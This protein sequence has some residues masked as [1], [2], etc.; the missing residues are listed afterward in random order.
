MRSKPISFFSDGFRGKCGGTRHSLRPLVS[1]IPPVNAFD[2][3]NAKGSAFHTGSEC[4]PTWVSFLLLTALVLP[5]PEIKAV[6]IVVGTS[7][8]T[9]DYLFSTPDHRRLCLRLISESLDAPHKGPWPRAVRLLWAIS[10]KGGK[11][12]TSRSTSASYNTRGH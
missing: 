6:S 8:S 1:P 7:R 9:S 2:H 12:S 11:S 3:L 10:R 5:V 4:S